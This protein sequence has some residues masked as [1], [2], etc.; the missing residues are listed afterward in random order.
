MRNIFEL[1]NVLF[2]RW[3]PL[4]SG[5]DKEFPFDV[6]EGTNQWDDDFIH[7]GKFHCWGNAYEQFQDSAGNYSVALV[8]LPDGTIAEVLPTNIKFVD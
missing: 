5:D 2:K 7:H 1:R 6:K 3:I 8:E 4:Q